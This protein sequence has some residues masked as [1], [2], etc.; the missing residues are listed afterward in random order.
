[1]PCHVTASIAH[2]Q[3]ALERPH[4]SPYL[5]NIFCLP[6]SHVKNVIRICGSQFTP[7]RL[8]KCALMLKNYYTTSI[9]LSQ[10]LH[11]AFPLLQR[12]WCSR[13]TH[14]ID[15][16]YDGDADNVS[17]INFSFSSVHRHAEDPFILWILLLLL[18]STMNYYDVL[19][20]VMLTAAGVWQYAE[21]KI[22]KYS[23]VI[24][25]ARKAPNN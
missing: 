3:R 8:P 17:P 11:A 21:W 1:M 25:S 12:I 10:F 22:G 13:F 5:Y 18:L 6:S 15:S 16:N 9:Y 24:Q 20:C 2:F 19:L 4:T 14:L 23:V 7:R